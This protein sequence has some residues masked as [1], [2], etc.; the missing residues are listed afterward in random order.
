M[1][2]SKSNAA[3]ELIMVADDMTFERNSFPII[4]VENEIA[5]YNSESLT[6][7]KLHNILQL[8]PS[9]NSGTVKTCIGFPRLIKLN[10]TSKGLCTYTPK[11]LTNPARV[12]DLY[13]NVIVK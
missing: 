1:K 5:V 12:L 9:L 11:E 8:H 6:F 13:K 7:Q 4:V 3:T 10:E 2:E